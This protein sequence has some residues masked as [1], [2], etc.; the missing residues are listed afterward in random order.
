MGLPPCSPS[1]S[2]YLPP[3]PP[4]LSL[5]S[6]FPVACAVVPVTVSDSSTRGRQMLWAQAKWTSAWGGAGLAS[7]LGL[8]LL[9]CLLDLRAGRFEVRESFVPFSAQITAS[10][11]WV[12]IRGKPSHVGTACLPVTTAVPGPWGKAES[13]HFTDGE[14]CLGHCL[15]LQRL[16]GCR[17]RM[18]WINQDSELICQG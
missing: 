6:E 2:F 3:P 10:E 13:A 15:L 5:P 1:P 4:P 12:K 14:M 9:C 7:S 18:H 8:P 17:C 16:A 11:I